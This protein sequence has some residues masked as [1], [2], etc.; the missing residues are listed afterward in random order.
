MR[1]LNQSCFYLWL[2]E[3]MN[4][5]PL[6][7]FIFTAFSWDGRQESISVFAYS[8]KHTID[9]KVLRFTDLLCFGKFPT[10]YV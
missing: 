10:T 3:E 1:D 8:R 9:L 5:L 4:K 6:N 2:F 7:Y